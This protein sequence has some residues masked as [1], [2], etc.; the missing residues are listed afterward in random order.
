VPAPL[1]LEASQDAVAA[2]LA[3]SAPASRAACTS[4]PLSVAR[5][6]AS[7]ARLVP[8]SG[9]GDNEDRRRCMLLAGLLPW[10]LAS[11]A[12][13]DRDPEV[14]AWACL[15]ARRVSWACEVSDCALWADLRAA[16]PT[17]H[18]ALDSHQGSVLVVEHGLAFLSNLA[19][20]EGF[21]VGA[22][23]RR[24][25]A[26]TTTLIT[27]PTPCTQH[28]RTHAHTRSHIA[29]PTP[30]ARPPIHSPTKPHPHPHP[31]VPQPLPRA[32]MEVEITHTH[33]HHT[34]TPSLMH[35]H[36][37]PRTTYTRSS[38]HLLLA[39]LATIFRPK[40]VLLGEV[41]PI[42]AAMRRH[43]TQVPILVRGLV[44][45]MNMASVDAVQVRITLRVG[46][47]IRAYVGRLYTT[48]QCLSTTSSAPNP[49]P[50]PHPTPH[51]PKTPLTAHALIP[52][53]PR[54]VVALHTLAY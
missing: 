5:S 16:L 12:R 13:H 18:R 29:Q 46:L 24:R 48:H 7:V 37:T 49:L 50:Q 4:N 45:L 40:E 42:L 38:P 30:H 23:A 8:R 41:P 20:E 53:N 39:P 31:Q 51:S 54:R 26:C 14:A 1:L 43:L 9:L 27:A 52:R 35:R 34:R 22:H 19:A 33:T 10:A 47:C 3:V 21:E 2:F 36:H 15:L 17:V 11:L 44:F 6:L 28:T 25:C 32:I